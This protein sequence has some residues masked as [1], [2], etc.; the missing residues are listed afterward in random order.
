MNI[1]TKPLS[2]D[3][4]ISIH[5]TSMELLE[6][7]GVHIEGKEILEIFQKAGALVDFNEERVFL[8]LS[9][10]NEILANCSPHLALYDTLG[11]K[12]IVFGQDRSHFGTHGFPSLYRDSVTG[13]IRNGT[14]R[15]LIDFL[16]VSEVLEYPQIVAPSLQPT[17][18]DSEIADLLQAKAALLTTKK[19]LYLQ[20]FSRQ[21]VH[22]IV[23]MLTA[24]VGG[25]ETLRQK[26]HTIFCV[27]THSPL[28][29]RKGAAE[30]LVESARLGAPVYITSG[31][32][33][34]ATSPVTLSGEL[35]QVNAEILSHVALSKIINPAAPVVYA[36]SCRMFDMKFG[37]CASS[38]PE[39]ALFRA[40]TSQLGKHYNLPTGGGGLNT[41]SSTIDAQYGWEK[42]MTTL[43]PAM[44]G[45]NI[46]LG[47]G[48]FSQMNAIS[49]ESLVVDS[50]IV[51]SVNRILNGVT[52]DEDRLAF[53]VIKNNAKTSDFMA[54]SHTMKYFKEEMWIPEGNITDRS[55]ANQWGLSGCKTTLD[56]ARSVVDDCLNEYKSLNIPENTRQNL[57]HIIDSRVK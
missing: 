47:M 23:K 36:S 29:I 43:L 35:A 25:K 6:K 31:A 24:V 50:D 16:K 11:E 45:Q 9:L 30:V 55:A 13:E 39:Y 19:P 54:D 51:R 52:V 44:A 1:N 12:S 27:C 2:G 10:M 26:P 3:E 22:D 53:E 34:G 15:E 38:T 41:D 48:I 8:P 14:Y 17:D 32:M 42:L 49:I 37:V 46:I 33:G 20:A 40:S 56:R 57:D 5:E 18:I 21:S 28:T 7:V 4:L